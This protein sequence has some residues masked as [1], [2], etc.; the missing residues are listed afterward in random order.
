MFDSKLVAPTPVSLSLI[1][2][3]VAGGL[4]GNS[5]LL[6]GDIPYFY[7]GTPTTTN[8]GSVSLLLRNRTFSE[9]G[10]PGNE[11]AYNAIFG[12]FDKNDPGVFNTFNQASTQQAFRNVYNQELPNYSG[13]LFEL[14]ANGS[15]ALVRAESESP[16]ALKGDRSGGW[17][18][19]IG[20]GANE[21]SGSIPGFH[22]GGLGFALGW[23]DALSTISSLGYTFSYLRGNIDDSQ[24][25]SGDH[26][27]GTIYALGVYFREEDGP[28]RIHASVNIGYASMD[29]QRYFNGINEDGS[30][31]TREATSTWSGATGRA[32]LGV[33]Y[34]EPLGDD[35]YVRPSL[36]G[37][38]F[39]L[40]EDAH[41]EHNGGSAFDLAYGSNFG[42]QGS[43]TGAVSFGM[44]LGDEFFWRPEVTVGWKQ[45][46][47]G[48]DNVD[49]QFQYQGAS[50]FTLNTPSQKSGAIAR[51]GVH[52]GDEFTDIA[53]EAGGEDRGSY[54][55]YDGQL[56]VRFGF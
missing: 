14:L 29:S 56:L 3:N 9:A 11:A 38:Y 15:D 30:S 23:E 39:M 12:A 25:G 10:V 48:P 55:A 54:R 34:E 8:T 42:K 20:F 1:T 49:A 43:A 51:I 22:G 6:L 7:V 50:S 37:D 35:F 17:A 26:Q 24:T 41:S 18:Q 13:G 5:Q 53:F 40:Y 21:S 33:E 44:K 2:G 27:V 45:V 47:G 52:G 36:S 32:H 31:F 4:Q 16:I 19:T 46:F 28:F